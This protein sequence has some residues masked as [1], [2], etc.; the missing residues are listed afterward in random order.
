MIELSVDQTL[1]KTINIGETIERAGPRNQQLIDFVD[2]K[3]R[4]TWLNATLGLYV[5]NLIETG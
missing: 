3:S 2:K 1:I 4:L 5:Q